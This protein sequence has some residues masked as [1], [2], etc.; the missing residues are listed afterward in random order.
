ME[1][2]YGL[3]QTEMIL[4]Y[5]TFIEMVTY[6][7]GGSTGYYRNVDLITGW[8]SHMAQRICDPVKANFLNGDAVYYSPFVTPSITNFEGPAAEATLTVYTGNSTGQEEDSL[9]GRIIAQNGVNYPNSI[10][11][12]YNSKELIYT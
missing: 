6:V 1:T 10:F 11:I 8:Y 5:D 7:T 4:V 2:S 12:A 3:N 9:P